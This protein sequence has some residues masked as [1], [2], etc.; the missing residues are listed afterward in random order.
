MRLMGSIGCMIANLVSAILLWWPML[1][2]GASDDVS[3]L[4]LTEERD[5][6]V[7]LRPC[8]ARLCAH[9]YAI[10]DP[11]VPANA[12]DE[13]NERPELRTRPICNLQIMGEL[14]RQPDNSWANG[15]VY[16]PKVGKRYSV[17][18]RLKDSNTLLVHGYVGFKLAGKTAAWTRTS[19]AH[20][21]VA[22]RS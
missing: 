17:E 19:E 1:A 6:V 15:W 4:W 22:T 20:R 7:E 14:Q 11:K 2:I 12:T 3:G 16:D 5:A 18:L 10:H 13:R 9:L 8:G 21:C